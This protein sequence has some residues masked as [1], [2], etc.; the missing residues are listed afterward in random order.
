LIWWR[1]ENA[2][3]LTKRSSRR[4]RPGSSEMAFSSSS[5]LVSAAEI[6]A[7][8]RADRRRRDVVADDLAR[9]ADEV[10]LEELEAGVSAVIVIVM[11]VDAV[12]DRAQAAAPELGDQRDELRRPD[13][14]RVHL[15]ERGEVQQPLG[16]GLSGIAVQGEHVAVLAQAAQALDER[17]VGDAVGR[18]LQDDALGPK[19]Q[20]VHR[21]Q[22]FG[23]DV[24]ERG[25]AAGGLA[26][27]EVAQGASGDARGRGVRA[28][29]AG[30]A[31][32]EQL[33]AGQAAVGVQDRLARK[34]D[35]DV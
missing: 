25:R 26:Q 24:E 35:L 28:L 33:I 12:G 5:M 23:G 30:L 10:A 14:A 1:S 22:E 27:A 9:A 21:Q 7:A 8:Q 17:L 18:D 13:R 2:A 31:A 29:G 6:P 20:R 3:L 4:L 34:E 32:V 19:G 16:G 11:R 15:G